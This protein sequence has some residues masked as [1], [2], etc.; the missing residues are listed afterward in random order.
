L[1]GVL[2]GGK[3]DVRVTGITF[4]VNG[5]VAGTGAAVI[6]PVTVVTPLAS[7]PLNVTGVKVTVGSLKL[8]VGAAPNPV[9]AIVTGVLSPELIVRGGEVACT[10]GTNDNGKVSH[11]A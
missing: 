11:I 6:V 8:S 10:G 1:A 4:N 5:I 7:G 3:E 2:G 9:P